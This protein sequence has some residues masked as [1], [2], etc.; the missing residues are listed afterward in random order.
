MLNVYPDHVTNIEAYAIINGAERKFCAAD[1]DFRLFIEK[2][3]EH[4]TRVYAELSGSEKFHCESIKLVLHYTDP[5]ADVGEYTVPNGGWGLNCGLTGLY[6]LK[7]YDGASPDNL[8]VCGLFGGSTEPSFLLASEIPGHFMMGY[9]AEMVDAHSAVLT[10]T[11]RYTSCAAGQTFVRTEIMDVVTGLPPVRA[12]QHYAAQM[13]KLQKDSHNAPLVGYNT[14]D[15]YYTD[16]G[17]ED[18]E[19]NLAAIRSSEA[20]KNHLRYFF[21]DD[22]WEYREGEWYACYRFPDGTR[23]IANAIAKDG[24]I[25]GIWVNGSSAVELCHIGLRHGEM[26]LK[27]EN[28]NAIIC[29]NMYVLDPTRPD[30]QKYYFD[31]FRRLYN[32]GFRAFKVDWISSYM[33]AKSFYQSDLGVY[34]VIRLLFKTIREAVGPDSHILGCSYPAECGP[35]YV[36]SA[37]L[38]I[39]IHNHWSHV[40][41]AMDYIQLSFWENEYVYTSDADFLV[42]RGS[43]TCDE[44]ETN[45][46]NPAPNAPIEPF[47][48][49]NRWRRGPVFNYDEAETW[50]NVVVFSAGNIVFSDRLS[51]LNDKGMELLATHLTANKAAAL[52]LDLGDQDEAAFWYSEEDGKLLIVNVFD[53]AREMVF[54]FGKYGIQAPAAVQCDKEADYAEGKVRVALRPHQSAVVCW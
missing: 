35:G 52:P 3:D 36:D 53:D 17:P 18:V 14:W 27:D 8:R 47:A 50:A 41:W 51:K 13:P 28:G 39:D 22:G 5:D 1:S 40:K 21:V 44:E 25:P 4:L 6:K 19:E 45:V 32:D 42:V 16:F 48:Q 15:Y 10:A 37:R 20:L 34:D 11:T 54:D 7:D 33:N 38:G 29:N 26:F 24:L 46:F 2:K 49:G 30:V 9:T 12:L 43:D 23:G 31:I